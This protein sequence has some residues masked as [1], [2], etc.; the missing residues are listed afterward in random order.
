MSTAEALAISLLCLVAA[1]AVA[2]DPRPPSPSPPG[3]SEATTN[4]P[5]R[6]SPEE[7][8]RRREARLRTIKKRAKVKAPRGNP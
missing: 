4:A 7:V 3:M 8:A 1:Y 2:D 6:L 5:P